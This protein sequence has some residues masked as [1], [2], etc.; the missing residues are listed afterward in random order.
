[1]LIAA[2]LPPGARAA[3]PPVITS[4]PVITGAPE[5]GSV[6]T[7]AATWP[8]DPPATAKWTWQRCN[9]KGA[10]C[11]TIR[12]AKAATYTA[13]GSDLGATLRV[14]LTLAG[15]GGSVTKRSEPTAVIAAAPVVTPTP[16]PTPA[17]TPAPEPPPPPAAAPPPPAA[18]VV[19]LVR[20]PLL[21]PFPV[22]HIKGRFTLTGARVTLLVVRAP[23]GG[24]IA[25]TCRGR[26]CP[27]RRFSEAS[28]VRR[29]RRFERSLRA[30]TRLQIT[31]TKPGYVGKVTVIVI[32]RHATPWRSD[33][34]LVPGA[35]RTVRCAAA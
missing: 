17:P 33:R 10:A 11:E 16:E 31:V 35:T 30:G 3:D 5:V 22:V 23:R 28:G 32:R 6:L 4:G 7:A 15:K 26:D 1:M 29:L 27:L 34:C 12:D 19:P 24:R 20:P 18:T 14:R 2:L 8:A 25:V 9:E 13:A 21:D